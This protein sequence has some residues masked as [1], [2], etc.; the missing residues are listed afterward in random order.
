ML[1]TPFELI[2]AAGGAEKPKSDNLSNARSRLV[3][4]PHSGTRRDR[5]ATG[6][7]AGA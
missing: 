5:Q 2:P 3:G 4:E 6:A 1:I 7:A